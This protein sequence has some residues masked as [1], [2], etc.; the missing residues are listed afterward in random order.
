MSETNPGTNDGTNSDVTSSGT[1]DVTGL[2]SALAAERQAAR[3]AKAELAATQ[4]QVATFQQ[5][6]AAH[7]AAIAE[8]DGTIQA[9]ELDLLRLNAAVEHGVPADLREFLTGTDQETLKAQAEKLIAAKPTAPRTPAPDPSQGTGG[10]SSLPL[11]GDPILAA[12]KGKLG[13]N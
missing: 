13:I 5:Q 9:R 3:E 7:E 4:A 12:L 2:K 8:R 6:I 11:N 1:E 10:G